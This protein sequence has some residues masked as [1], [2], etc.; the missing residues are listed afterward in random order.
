MNSESVARILDDITTS[1]ATRAGGKA[2]NCAR[3]K[4]AGIPVPDGIVLTTDAMGASLHMPELHE[5]LAA[6]PKN[7][8][9]A[10]RS[11]GVDEDGAGH[12]F[13]GIHETTLNVEPANLS[14][15]VKS[16]WASV[17][18][19]QAVAY[20]R[21]L[22]LD[23]HNPKTA[24][25]IQR[26]IDPVVSGV[27]FTINPITG[28]RNEVLVNS[29]PGLGDAL[30]S[31]LIQPDE[32]R[33]EKSTGQVIF[34]Q[35]VGA[36]P[37]LTNQQ[38]RELTLMLRTIEDLYG[39]PQDVEW[40]YDGTQFWVVQSRP[41]TGA[42]TIK[43]IEWTRA[44]IREVLPDLP[45]PMTV[46]S[47]A[48]AI[49]EAERKFY[50]R[51]LAPV[52]ELGRM[53]R[54]F[55]GR[56]YFNV[57]QIRYTCRMSG[58][59][60]GDILR[61]LGHEGDI[62]PQDEIAQR[63]ST[64]EF[65]SLFPDLVN[66]LV[67]Q[68]AVARLANR[69]FTRTGQVVK[70]L[71]SMEF[72]QLPDTEL[73]A[74]NRKWKQEL[75]DELQLVFT[76][77]G[78]SIYE[79][80]LRTICNRAGISYE[81]L[82]HTHLAAGDK[83]VSSSQGF[84]ILRLAH[85]ARNETS[86]RNYFEAAGTSFDDYCQAL[87]GTGFMRSFQDFLK[88]YGHR[89][90]YESDIAIPKYA[91]DPSAVLFAIQSHVQA[92]EFTD[93]EALI[94][95]QNDEAAKAW[96]EFSS[97]LNL[98]R[99]LTLLPQARW[100][101]RRIKQFYLWRELA[102]S[103]MVRVAFQIRRIHLEL[104]KRFVERN[105]ISNRDDY[106]SLTVEEID[107]VMEGRTDGA[108]LASI[109]ARRK[110]EWKRLAQI[111][112]PLL[113]RESQLSAIIRRFNMPPPNPV[114]ASQFKGLCISA[115]YVEGEVIVM[116]D[117]GDF[118]RMKRGAILV[119]TATDPSWTPLFTLASGVI[120]EVGGMLSHA[121]TVAREYGLPGLANIRHATKIFKDGDRIRLD[122]TNGTVEIL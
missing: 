106:F 2:F 96:I 89:G 113:M 65:I 19:P 111:E 29:A 44:N 42:K 86:A 40:C 71:Q 57:E 110:T 7:T 107:H 1:E 16:C 59:A 46:Y 67:R 48:D 121:S 30:V 17:M 90:P 68:L 81:R 27:A 20:R 80:P 21:A 108:A 60:V 94:R 117:P 66:M 54:V 102:R 25:L 97:K 28:D 98:W 99:R 103:E 22:G 83:S 18:S 11:S 118:A 120:V 104:A 8:T 15:A 72:G 12:S 115:G 45:T 10:V 34:S 101:L 37:T 93:P 6:L 58:T 26:M 63:P 38:L 47:I 35:P 85:I 52:E 49:E 76:L 88:L 62:A 5:W 41:V 43:D 92:A 95:R 50:G 74:E 33:I 3:L 56:I 14:A 23:A 55:Y 36:T 77:A 112:M 31:G 73:W 61:S 116:R 24:V 32:F 82:A 51:Y 9:L 114:A 87:E 122:A 78:V 64:R 4:Q 79:K 53:A 39:S 109:A 119:T 100:L 13:A 70:R 91:E 84:D 75:I 69:Q 105:W